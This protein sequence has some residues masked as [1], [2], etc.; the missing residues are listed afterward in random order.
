MRIRFVR[1]HPVLVIRVPEWFMRPRGGYTWCFLFISIVFIRE[2]FWCDYGLLAHEMV[3]VE[4]NVRTLYLHP[5]LYALS[6]AYRLGSEVEAYRVQMGCYPGSS[7]SA[8]E[9]KFAGYLCEWYDLGIEMAEALC[10]LR[11]ED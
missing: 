9:L 8:L 6:R 5:V 10:L 1:F 7:V 3:H 2:N 11:G 4:Q